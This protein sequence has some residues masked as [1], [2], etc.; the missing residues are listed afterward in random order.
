MR[1]G[2]TP[3]SRAA[4]R[5]RLREG[6]RAADVEVALGEP[7]GE[8]GELGGVEAD[9]LARADELVQAA[10]ALGDERGDLVAQ[11]QV[12]AARRAQDHDHVGVLGQFL[13]QRADRGD[14]DAGA[15]QQDAIVLTGVG[16]ED[17]VGPF[18]RDTGARAQAGEARRCGRRDP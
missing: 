13:Q 16:G 6:V 18:D 17:A 4:R 15:D 8:R 2:A 5:D 3:A 1:S 14:A 9:A 7:G 12:L 10:V 11:D